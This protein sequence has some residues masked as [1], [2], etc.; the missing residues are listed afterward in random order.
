MLLNVNSFEILPKHNG[1]VL[2][3]SFSFEMIYLYSIST[4][5]AGIFIVILALKYFFDLVI[6]IEYLASTVVAASSNSS[7]GPSPRTKISF[8]CIIS[9]HKKLLSTPKITTFYLI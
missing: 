1:H 4:Q 6:L 9:M 2:F 3:F 7:V 8:Y 5:K